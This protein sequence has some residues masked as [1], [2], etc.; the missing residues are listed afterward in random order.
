MEKI[1]I[2]IC[3]Y[4]I[5]EYLDGNE[6]FCMKNIYYDNKLYLTTTKNLTYVQINDR[7]LENNRRIK[8]LNCNVS[9]TDAGI[10]DLP[11][12]TL[13]ASSKITNAGIKGM[14]LH[15]LSARGSKITDDGIRGMPLHTLNASDSKITDDG[16]RGMLLRTIHVSIYMTDDGIRGMPIHTL[17]ACYSRLTDD[18]IKELSLRTLYAKKNSR[19]TN[20]VF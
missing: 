5:M 20:R 17:Y 13:Y 12:H 2:E 11:L 10:K 4:Y 7:F 3:Q 6:Q 18:G 14:S 16:I 19:L 9:V 8:Y 15:T 1:P